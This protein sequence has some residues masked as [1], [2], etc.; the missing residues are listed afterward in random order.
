MSI[1]DASILAV[2]LR[3]TAP[4]LLATI[5]AVFSE[6]A[7]VPNITLE[8]AMLCGAFFGV[9]GSYYSGSSAVGALLAVAAGLAVS[10]IFSLFTLR[11]GGDEVVV[12]VA[13]NVIIGGLTIFLLK[14][15]FHT[16]GSFVSPE[17][18]GFPQL[19]I[20]LLDQ[21]PVVKYLFTGQTWIVYFAFLSVA[22][23]HVLLYRTP[24]GMKVIACGE[25]PLAAATV[26]VNVYRIRLISILITGAL[27][28]LAGAQISLGFLSMFSENMTAGRGF[29]AVAAVIFARAVPLRAL[30]ISLLFGLAEALSNQLQLMKIPSELVLML[31][32]LL[33]VVFLVVRPGRFRWRRVKPPASPAGSGAI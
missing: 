2:I 15:I 21:I 31:P 24:F 29:I 33:V 26:G 9:L 25:N 28:G 18:K 22:I 30:F 5:G 12:G 32:Y 11:W 27:C 16:S 20:P 3:V 7:G 10:L 4:I 23:A 19:H 1:I 14:T 6:K 13:I 17:I 8:P